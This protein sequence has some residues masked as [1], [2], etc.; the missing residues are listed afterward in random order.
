MRKPLFDKGG[1]VYADG[2]LVMTDG[3]TKLYLVEPDPAAFKPVASAELLSGGANQNWAPLALSDGK[4]LIRDQ[5]Q[6]MCVKIIK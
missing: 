6:L 1:I 5:K 2:L 4:L 3:M